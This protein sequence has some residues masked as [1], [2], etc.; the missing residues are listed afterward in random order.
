MVLDLPTTA[1]GNRCGHGPLAPMG[2]TGHPVHPPPLSQGSAAGLGG[3]SWGSCSVQYGLGGDAVGVCAHAV[4]GDGEGE[5]PSH[6]KERIWH[7]R[8]SPWGGG[9]Q[10]RDLLDTGH[11]SSA[12][13]CPRVTPGVKG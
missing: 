4:W 5:P 13:V 9:G 12:A 2:A 11:W 6:S 1:P 3:C 8:V 10:N 7:S